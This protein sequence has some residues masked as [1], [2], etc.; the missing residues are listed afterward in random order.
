MFSEEGETVALLRA[1][2]LDRTAAL[3]SLLNQSVLTVRLPYRVNV[4]TRYHTTSNYAEVSI[5]IMKDILLNHTKAF[6]IVTVVEYRSIIW[7]QYC[8]ARPLNLDTTAE[9]N[10]LPSRNCCVDEWRTSL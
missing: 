9:R 7:E 5:S 1:F 6:N 4:V 8:K 2:L 10:R 3:Q